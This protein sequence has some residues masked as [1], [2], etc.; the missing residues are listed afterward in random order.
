MGSF[1]L[2]KEAFETCNYSEYVLRLQKR[3]ILTQIEN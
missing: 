2:P 1:T 3:Q